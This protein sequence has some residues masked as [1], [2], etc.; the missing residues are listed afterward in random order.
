MGQEGSE[1]DLDSSTAW[2]Q[3][4]DGK[5]RAEFPSPKSHFDSHRTLSQGAPCCLAPFRLRVLP[6][7]DFGGLLKRQKRR[8]FLFPGFHFLSSLSAL[9]DLSG[10][11]S[12]YSSDD[13]SGTDS[14]NSGVQDLHILP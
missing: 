6:G 3:T 11:D 8:V 12:N 1:L 5:W 4:C 10:M 13:I 14:L 7:L 2:L 9:V